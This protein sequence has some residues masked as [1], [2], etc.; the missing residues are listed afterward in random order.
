MRSWTIKPES[1][2][3]TAEFVFLLSFT[4]AFLQKTELTIGRP[5]AL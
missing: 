5:I 2:D 4:G 1:I 3:A